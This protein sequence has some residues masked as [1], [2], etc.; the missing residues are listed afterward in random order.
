MEKVKYTIERYDIDN[1]LK[2]FDG[3]RFQLILATSKRAREIANSRI[4]ADR[5]EM[6][7]YDNKPVVEALCEVDQGKIGK[8][9]LYKK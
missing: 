4:F 9:Y 5:K 2:A 1:C 7:I 3:N 6:G 8:D